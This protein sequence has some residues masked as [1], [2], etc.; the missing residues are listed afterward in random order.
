M[1]QQLV[2]LDAALFQ[3]AIENSYDV[4][5]L[6]DESGTILYASPSIESI[7][8]LTPVDIIGTSGYDLVHPEDLPLLLREL[9]GAMAQGRG[10]VSPYRCHTASGEWRWLKSTGAV[11]TSAENA[12]TLLI[13]SRD[14]T[15]S[16]LAEAREQES[17]RFLQSVLDTIAS[18]IA[19]LDDA[20]TV[21]AVNRAWSR[22]QE[23]N[24]GGARCGV[25]ANYLEVC[26]RSRGEGA[27]EAHQVARG[28]RAV[29]AGEK[30]E[31]TLEYPCHNGA[32]KRWFIVRVTRFEEAVPARLV[33]SHENVTARKR[34]ELSN[35]FYT[36][37][38]E[39]TDD[40]II[41]MSVDAV[42]NH[43]NSGAEKFLG[44]TAEE[45][46]GRPYDI[47][48]P[49]HRKD[50]YLLDKRAHVE[51][52]RNVLLEKPLMRK[53]GA[54]VDASIQVSLVRDAAGTVIG[55]GAIARD[56][57]EEKRAAEERDRFFTLSLDL[58]CIVDTS[59]HFKR[60]NP[61]F[62]TVLGFS[63]E[64]ME[65]M[66]HTDLLHP[67]DL[68]ASNA[69]MAQLADG[70]SIINFVN[71]FRCR[72]GSYRSISWVTAPYGKVFYAAG[73]DITELLLA[74]QELE[75]SLLLLEATL[76]S[77][78][79]GILVVDEGGA[80]ARSNGKFVE[81]WGIP[82]EIMVVSGDARVLEY[83]R[84]QLL[85]PEMLL[86]G[87]QRAYTEPDL[88]GFDLLTLKDGRVFERYTKT[89]CLGGTGLSRVW[90]FRDVT[91]RQHSV[92]A[93]LQLNG[94]LE[95]QRRRLDDILSNVP[96][97]VWESAVDTSTGYQKI[98][99]VSS[100]LETMLGYTVEE[101]RDSPDSWWNA[102]HPDDRE[103]AF[104]RIHAILR[105]S[106]QG[107]L[108]YRLLTKSGAVLST[109]THCAA[110][111]DP[112]GEPTGLR[113]VTMDVSERMQ[114]VEEQSRLAALLESTTDFVSWTDS[115]CHARYVNPA[116]R[117]L[118][119]LDAE[120]SIEGRPIGDFMAGWARD[121]LFNE[122]MPTATEKGSWSGETAL[123]GR[124]G[125]EV[126]VSQVITAHKDIAGNT[127][128]F[129]T[130]ARDISERKAAEAAMRRY[131]DELEQQVE[132]RTVQLAESNRE[133]QAQ[134]AERQMAVGALQEVLG[135]LQEAKDEA[136]KA[137]RAKSEFLSRMSHELRT[138][139]NA[140]LGFGQILEMDEMP[141]RRKEGV[142]HILKAGQ[143]LLNLINEVLD[144]SRIEAGKLSL[145]KE[146]VLMDQ[147]VREVFD[148]LRHQAAAE[149][150]ELVDQ[151]PRD[152]AWHVL[153]DRQRLLQVLLNLGSNAIK[154]NRPGGRA[155]VTAMETSDGKSLRVLVQ[156]TGAGLGEEDLAKLFTPF[157]RLGAANTRIEGTGIG[158]ALCR[159]LMEEMEGRIGVESV[160]GSG[161]VFWIE[162]P[163]TACPVQHV[164]SQLQAGV[165]ADYAAGSSQTPRRTVLYIEDNLPN[166]ELIEMLLQERLN[167][168]LL[169]A[170]QAS[171]GLE[172]ASS[173]HPDLI[174]LD[175][176][177]PDMN[178]EE[179][180]R[181]LRS[182]P[183]TMDIPVVIISADATAIQIERLRDAGALKYLTKPLDVKQ[184][185]MVVQ[186]T[187]EKK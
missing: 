92:D 115:S 65:S 64:E 187:L 164:R 130:I 123:A 96:G 19:V 186:E 168:R 87:A 29:L 67:D 68:E 7:T 181:R 51:T 40:A 145:S 2:D 154:Y 82:G 32:E 125:T 31:F 18:Q 46:V 163:L 144:I 8:G 33:V 84:E 172:F 4:I 75:H 42:I 105:G 142:G 159:R 136:D 56:I 26:D 41:G 53:D 93:Q 140:I 138:P 78:A 50:Q 27:R 94:Q 89:H 106:G 166:L 131:N 25:G 44:Y 47:L 124:D 6:L 162:L 66:V 183:A 11:L 161:S 62:E 85:F 134:I 104:A 150:I 45:I 13:N 176:H 110:I 86:E 52:G 133:L 126:P 71:R 112:A 69:A 1:L 97:I 14:I 184:F 171:T 173:H 167:V 70:V 157:E 135:F 156:D 98:V 103:G 23:E 169:T 74:Q 12:K 119:G 132:S 59:G 35:S 149:D 55:R 34:A 9:H 39:S 155:T 37:I 153:A 22:V 114:A 60:V 160:P 127:L 73:H 81:M 111:Y 16:K 91:E 120:E 79:D 101:W 118:L 102:V 54:I 49:S 30:T 24:D 137:N 43:W 80:I 147:A 57:T 146:P 143:H 122:A 99:Y 180:L 90:S 116:G 36:N 182:N 141:P 100:Y 139:L 128:F 88:E 177:L 20:G 109:E 83:V 170:M 151:M 15:E 38:V 121:L 117:A 174:L 28:I 152:K 76:E 108:Q 5:E 21:I 178:G 58:L 95:Q 48:V 175:L 72:D 165:V 61:A 148:L 179:V 158:L 77:T 63:P 129:S 17:R 185:L 113:G 107:T 3:R 10:E